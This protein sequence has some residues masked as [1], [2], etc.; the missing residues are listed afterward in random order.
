[1]TCLIFCSSLWMPDVL[2]PAI[3]ILLHP[4]LAPTAP[5]CQAKANCL[6]SGMKCLGHRH[7]SHSN[8]ESA[9]QAIDLLQGSVKQL[10][11][12]LYLQGIDLPD[13][14]MSMTR[15]AACLKH[16]S[17]CGLVP[18]S[19]AGSNWLVAAMIRHWHQAD[20]EQDQ[21][22]QFDARLV[23]DLNKSKAALWQCVISTFTIFGRE[24]FK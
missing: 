6:V 5:A 21:R 14:A 17:C 24:P 12:C 16:L 23:P 8:P 2:C 10:H 11:Q 9:T 3:S 20:Y 4:A 7:C 1:M 19:A 13:K 18:T 22:R 15:D